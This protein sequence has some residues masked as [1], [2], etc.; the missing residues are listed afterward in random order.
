[1]AAINHNNEPAFWHMPIDDDVSAGAE[2]LCELVQPSD[3]RARVE[4]LAM[5]TRWFGTPL[6]EEDALELAMSAAIAEWNP[7][8]QDF[9][10]AESL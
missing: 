5:V 7:A 3:D 9:S 6:S 1:M 10:K 2:V 8:A 4:T